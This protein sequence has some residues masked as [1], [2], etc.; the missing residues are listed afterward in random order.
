QQ[1]FVCGMSGAAIMCAHEGCEHSFHLP[2]AEDGGCVT[3]FFG[4]YR[5]FCREHRP[6]Q[7]VQA[8]PSADTNCII[9]LDPVGDCKSYYTMVCPVCR[10]A[11]F[12]RA[13]IQGQARSAGVLHFRCPICQDKEKFCSEM[14]TMG[15]QI[16]V[17]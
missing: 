2:C 16:P 14:S 8:D 6:Q 11:W 9:C 7:T 15:I 13:C 3:Q 10:N 5:S 12:H 4:Q 1:C 17:R